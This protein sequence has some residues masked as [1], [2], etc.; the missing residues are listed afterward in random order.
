VQTSVLSRWRAS[1]ETTS[2]QTT[3]GDSVKAT[4]P[5]SSFARP[6]SRLHT[7]RV[8][9]RVDRD[10]PRSGQ[11]AAFARCWR[12]CRGAVMSCTPWPTTR[13]TCS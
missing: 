11:A 12:R 8:R 13:D 10:Q 4:T 7:V 9:L 6:G 5:F 3:R 2:R 1:R